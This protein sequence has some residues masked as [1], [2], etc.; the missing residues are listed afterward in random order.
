MPLTLDVEA[1]PF[2]WQIHIP[3]LNDQKCS[4]RA[5]V[6]S[7]LK[8]IIGWE[9]S[10]ARTLE[11]A[12]TEDL[13]VWVPPHSINGILWRP[14]PVAVGIDYP[15]KAREAWSIL[16]ARALNQET[17]TYGDM[18]HALG[19]LHPLHDVPQ[20]LDVIQKWCHEE[21]RP[22]LT[23]LVVSQRSQRPGRDYWRQN[24]WLDLPAEQQ[25]DRWKQSLVQLAKDPGPE[26][27]P[28]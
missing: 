24:G 1:T 20:V 17:L 19:G 14:R 15:A 5:Q 9:E 7:L 21:S 12:T 6:L 26:S 11:S 8:Q 25:E 13:W 10:F 16:A 3:S 23:G 2:G 22:D 27:A 18:G 4:P 28:F